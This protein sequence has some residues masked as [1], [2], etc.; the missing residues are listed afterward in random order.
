MS[1][2]RPF[3]L[4]ILLFSIFTLMLIQQTP[5]KANNFFKWLLNHKQQEYQQQ[6]IKIIEQKGN[7]PIKKTVIQKFKQ[8]RKEENTKRI[9]IIGDFVASAIADA[10]K[11]LFAD[12][13]D[14]IIINKTIPNSGLV[15]TDYYSWKNNIFRLIDKNNPHVIV[16]MIGANDNQPITTP[17]GIFSTIQPEWMTLY[18]Q[19]ITEI[20]ESL[21][22]SGKPWFWIGQPIFQN[23]DLTQKI[24]IF[25]TLYKNI[26][27]ATG[28][29]FI[30]LWNGFIDEKGQFSFSGYNKDGNIV[31]LRT[32]D[33]IN[34]TSEGK[35]KL[36]SYLEKKLE[37][38]LGS[39]IL[40]HDSVFFANFDISKPLQEIQH[41]V[42]QAPM[43]LDAMAQQNTNLLNS[44]EQKFI[45]KSW[46][47]P[48]GHQKDRA[49]NFFLP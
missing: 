39:Q 41:I 7:K 3:Y 25:N 10:L 27:E 47:F 34:F 21:H 9:L 4:I 26:T 6:K 14:I 23:S 42:R 36:A 15:R 45:K 29:Y 35:K 16:I 28:G 18:K 44:V 17:H 20:A 33:G 46:H 19:R 43:S 1:Y 22:S 37:N 40:P 13:N 2:F 24:K 12:N 31:R 32:N 11:T 30:D 38:I 8:K 5:S 48:N 49:D